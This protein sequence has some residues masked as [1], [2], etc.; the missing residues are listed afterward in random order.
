VR[1]THA[2]AR[3]ATSIPAYHRLTAL[4]RLPT[5]RG[6]FSRG[7]GPT[8]SILLEEPGDP[9]V[10]PHGQ[11]RARWSARLVEHPRLWEVAERVDWG[12]VDAY[13]EVEVRAGAE[14]GAADIADHLSLDDVLITRDRDSA[15]VRVG[16][17]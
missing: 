2:Q 13:F 9:T 10:T 3:G 15:L 8:S 14:A 4:F 1:C 17:R 7:A 6:N 12:A 16:S 11:T 5:T